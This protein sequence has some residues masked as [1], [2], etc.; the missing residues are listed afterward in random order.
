MLTRTLASLAL[1]SLCSLGCSTQPASSSA[2]SPRPTASSA[3]A[4]SEAT[5]F[6]PF[7][8]AEKERVRPR[9]GTTYVDVRRVVNG[10]GLSFLTQGVACRDAADGACAAQLRELETLSPPNTCLE[11]RC[12]EVVYALTT[13]KDGVAKIEGREAL[14]ALFGAIDTPTEAWILAMAE[15]HVGPISCD[16][17]E[18]AAHQEQKS[19]FVLRER[20]YSKVCDPIEVSEALYRVTPAG[21]IS[22]AGLR[23]YSRTE[24]CTSG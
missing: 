12:P 13:T 9:A 6:Q 24:G 2:P 4:A 22:P 20:W 17:L 15:S 18:F 10:V 11:R 23:L 8:C 19:E 1:F 21:F 14:L 3:A 16:S 7:S 5:R